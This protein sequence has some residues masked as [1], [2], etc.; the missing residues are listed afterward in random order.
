ML[1][2][3]YDQRGECITRVYHLFIIHI[4]ARRSAF[5]A[6]PSHQYVFNTKACLTVYDM[7]KGR[8]SLGLDSAIVVSV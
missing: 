4:F 1:V 8:M 6:R 2:K 7:D 3:I 5:E